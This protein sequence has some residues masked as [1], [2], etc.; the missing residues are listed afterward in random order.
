MP[1]T[2]RPATEADLPALLALYAELHPDD[3]VLAPS[4]A[5][6]TWRDIEAQ[7]GRH[8]LLA[9]SDAVA[10]GT[11]DCTTLPN[12]TRGGRPFMLVENVVVTASRRR[13][14]IGAALLDAAVALARKAGCYKIQLLSRDTRLDAHAFYAARG[15]RTVA[16]GY[17]LYLD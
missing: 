11:V 10:V 9:E 7:A 8:V 1:V 15:F 17:R 4:A 2:I 16:K 13:S 12:L 5:A 3:P 14:G 6:R